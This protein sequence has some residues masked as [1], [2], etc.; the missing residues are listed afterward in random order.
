QKLIG[1]ERPSVG[2]PRPAL[3]RA[4]P[5]EHPGEGQRQHLA[6]SSYA[7]VSYRSASARADSSP[8]NCSRPPSTPTR[9]LA[10][11]KNSTLRARHP[12]QTGSPDV[13]FVE[14]V[15]QMGESSILISETPSKFRELRQ[16]HSLAVLLLAASRGLS[17]ASSRQRQTSREAGTQS[18]GSGERA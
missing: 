2:R 15:C 14:L 9:I 3:G 12:S 4:G 17:R 18:H 5:N 10:A 13:S 7:G 6:P 8:L 1:N 11:R 16:Q